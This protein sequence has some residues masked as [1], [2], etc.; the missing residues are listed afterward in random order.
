MGAKKFDMSFETQETKLLGR[1]SRDFLGYPEG[2]PKSLR[3][4]SSCSIFVP[5]KEK[6]FRDGYPADVPGHLCSRV[7]NSG[8]PSKPGKN[9]RLGADMHDPNAWT[10][11][12]PRV[13]NFGQKNFGLVFRSIFKVTKKQLKSVIV[14]L[15]RSAPK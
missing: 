11:M 15:G 13:P 12:T 1:I 8:R 9:K 4:E 6:G 10:S 7:K 5:Y 14:T 3:R 2:C